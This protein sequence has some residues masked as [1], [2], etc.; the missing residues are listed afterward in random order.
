MTK[1]AQIARTADSVPSQGGTGYPEIFAVNIVDRSKKALGDA[2]GL[3]NFGVNLVTL[4]VG[5]ISSQRHWHS[6]QDE[7]V[8]VL[9]GELTLITNDGEQTIGPGMVAGFAAG[10]ENGH[11]LV[12]RGQDDAVYLEVGDRSADDT[13]EYP[14][15]DMRCINQDGEDILIHKN[16]VP[17]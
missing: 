11:Q 16:G 6:K 13:V 17:Y 14:D 5:E 10:A 8:Y 1:S 9:Q 2:F 3:T 4:P 12:N 7:L 15:I